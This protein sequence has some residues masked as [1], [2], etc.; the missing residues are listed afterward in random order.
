MPKSKTDNST[1][2]ALPSI[3]LLLKSES[4]RR[5]KGE[6]GAEKLASIAR[7]VT[8]EI[9][10]EMKSRSFVAE[11][12]STSENGLREQLMQEAERR[13]VDLHSSQ[14]AT[15]L[16]RVINATGVIL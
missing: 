10:D 9:R 1:L 3:D 8:A 14:K 16:Q 5:L 11:S 6:I 12:S 15:G 13:L 2:R 7:Q 4:A